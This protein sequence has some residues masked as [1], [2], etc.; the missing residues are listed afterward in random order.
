[1]C[2]AEFRRKFALGKQAAMCTLAALRFMSGRQHRHLR[3]A[4]ARLMQ[5]QQR[6]A[7][8]RPVVVFVWQKSTGAGSRN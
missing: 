8:T 4:E 6:C 7:V 2:P 5:A 3:R 1:M